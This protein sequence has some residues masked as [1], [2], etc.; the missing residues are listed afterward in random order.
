MLVPTHHREARGR[1]R[2]SDPLHLE[3]HKLQYVSL[4]YEKQLDGPLITKKSF[5]FQDMPWR[6]F[7]DPH[8]VTMSLRITFGDVAMDGTVTSF[9]GIYTCID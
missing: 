6:T 5:S 3:N 2:G 8:R 7:R 1:G 4:E 9:S